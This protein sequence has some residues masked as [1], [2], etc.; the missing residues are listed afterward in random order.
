[1]LAEVRA[2]PRCLTER[3]ARDTRVKMSKLKHQGYVKPVLR[4]TRVNGSG[5]QS[6]QEGLWASSFQQRQLIW[7][8]ADP[9]NPRVV[10]RE[11]PAKNAKYIRCFLETQASISEI[12]RYLVCN[13]CFFSTFQLKPC[14]NLARTSVSRLSQQC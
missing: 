2:I 8:L 12:S 7:T 6:I 1:M 10:C 13:L 4:G 5:S 3:V 14:A 9:E 11:L